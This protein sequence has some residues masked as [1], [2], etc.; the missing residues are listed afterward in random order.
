MML[1]SIARK[2]TRHRGMSPSNAVIS[3]PDVG[4]L[5]SFS[6]FPKDPAQWLFSHCSESP[7][8]R[9]LALMRRSMILPHQMKD[10]QNYRAVPSLVATIFW[11][12]L[13]PIIMSSTDGFSETRDGKL[14]NFEAARSFSIS[15]YKTVMRSADSRASLVVSTVS[16]T[17]GVSNASMIKYRFTRYSCPLANNV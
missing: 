13:S 6:R 14:H 4:P 8:Y 9:T 3:A 2:S 7:S 10:S 12:Q 15:L 1:R 11:V 5:G 17:S 16:A